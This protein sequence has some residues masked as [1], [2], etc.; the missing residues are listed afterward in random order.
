M[1]IKA[2]SNKKEQKLFEDLSKTDKGKE[3]ITA[4][5]IIAQMDEEPIAISKEIEPIFLQESSEE[6][7]DEIE[8]YPTTW[9]EARKDMF[10]SR[11]VEKK[12]GDK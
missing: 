6:D 8:P 1:G 10:Y 4:A 2:T 7:D 3:K 12:R 9:E 5:K 11:H